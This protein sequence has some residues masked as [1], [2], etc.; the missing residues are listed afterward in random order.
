MTKDVAYH[1]HL[2]SW[3]KFLIALVLVV[4]ATISVIVTMSTNLSIEVLGLFVAISGV[5]LLSIGLVRTN[6]DLLFLAT[7]HKQAEVQQVIT[8]FATERFLVMLS[9]F[10]IVLGM[11][12]Q[13]LGAVF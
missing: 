9:L 4:I 8:H 7:H 1:A 13:L 11:L 12:L 6:D 2:P 5:L 10:L 3:Q